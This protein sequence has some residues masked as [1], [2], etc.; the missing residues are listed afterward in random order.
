MN[1]SVSI[2]I[3]ILLMV[4][5]GKSGVAPKS[6]AER[7][8]EVRL[9]GIKLVS[10]VVELS[11][12]LPEDDVCQLRFATDEEIEILKQIRKLPVEERLSVLSST[13]EQMSA[14]ELDHLPIEYVSHAVVGAD[15]NCLLY[16]S[17]SPRDA[18]L[19]RMPSS[20]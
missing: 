4:G 19:S 5:C 10:Q 11:T 13:I 16:T 14:G 15:T 12:T 9:L 7:D 2:V 18:T 3:L 20:A 1:K 6:S 8:E 17:P